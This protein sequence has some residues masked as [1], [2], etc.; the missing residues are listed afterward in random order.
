MTGV[1]LNNGVGFFPDFSEDASS[2]VVQFA[3]LTNALHP[4]SY[5]FPSRAKAVLLIDGGSV[6]DSMNVGPQEIDVVNYSPNIFGPP[7]GVVEVV[8]KGSLWIARHA[9]C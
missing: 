5:E 1:G 4:G 7:S 9:S 3:K 6:P 8:P 2:S